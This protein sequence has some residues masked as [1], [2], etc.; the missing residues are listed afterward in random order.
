MLAELDAT[1]TPWRVTYPEE[2]GLY[3]EEVEVVNSYPGPTNTNVVP[4]EMELSVR[5]TD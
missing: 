3:F 2:E 4:T 1:I 5:R